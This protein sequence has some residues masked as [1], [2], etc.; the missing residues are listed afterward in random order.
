MA[1]SLGVYGSSPL[2]LHIL[3]CDTAY[4]ELVPPSVHASL[5]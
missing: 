3:P 2:V 5:A 1:T 4:M